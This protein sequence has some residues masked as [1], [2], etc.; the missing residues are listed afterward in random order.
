[1]QTKNNN[2]LR[3]AKKIAQSG[4]SSRREAEKYITD[5][6]VKVNGVE[7]SQL[8]YQVTLKDIVSIDDKRIKDEDKVRIWKFHKPKGLVTSHRDEK[9]RPT[10]FQAL[11]NNLPRLIS[12][13]R[14]DLNSEGLLLL[15][16]NGNVKRALELPKNNFFRSYKVRA[17][18]VAEE[19]KLERLRN[20]ISVK[21]INYRPMKVDLVNQSASNVWLNVGLNEGKN[22][23]IRLTFEA[24]GLKVSRLKIGRAHV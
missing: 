13:G 8:S 1:M 7:V 18:G 5:G 21:G 16:N 15:T 4:F 6:R 23:E 2:N 12:V 3:L 19:R 17:H 9:G 24:I 22:R 20:G 10:V 14:L 11:P